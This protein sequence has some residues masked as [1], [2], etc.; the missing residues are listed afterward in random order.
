MTDDP[1]RAHLSAGVLFFDDAGR[2]MLVEPTYKDYWDIPG[3]YVNHGESPRAAA[4]RE[5]REEL[6]LDVSPGRL[7][8][9]D[10]APDGTDGDK[11]LFVFDGGRLEAAQVAAIR[12]QADEIRSYAYRAPQTL[13]AVTIER[14][15]RRLHAAV[16]ARATGHTL[17]LERGLPT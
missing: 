7:L 16:E 6:G 14:L 9:T 13:A 1:A 10:W 4:R 3:G 11:L 2:I 15:V 8:V 5:V 17:L 12:L